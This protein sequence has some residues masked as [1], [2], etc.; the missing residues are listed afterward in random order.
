[1][2]FWDVADKQDWCVGR[3]LDTSTDRMVAVEF[4]RFNAKGWAYNIE[5]IRERHHR[6]SIGHIDSEGHGSSKTIIDST[7]VGDVVVDALSDINAEAFFFTKQTKDEV[8]TG[9][10][11]AMSL[12][13]FE[14]P[15]IA[16]EYDELKFYEREDKD[17]V[18]DCVM[19]LAG[20]VHFGRRQP[21]EYAGWV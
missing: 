11:E 12:R 14:M 18:Q 13:R 20:A 17:L 8:L 19:S 15:M 3:T 5:R 21:Y 2:H 6:Y 10:Q 7:G 9:L 16:V 4:E 1:V